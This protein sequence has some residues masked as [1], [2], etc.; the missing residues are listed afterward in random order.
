ME[1]I[2]FHWA[3][4]EFG[5]AL[6][7]YILFI[8]FLSYYA[9]LYF[10]HLCYYSVDKEL[11]IMSSPIRCPDE[12][13]FDAYLG[14]IEWL[15]T[16][17]CPEYNSSHTPIPLITPSPKNLYLHDLMLEVLRHLLY[18]AAVSP[19]VPTTSSN[20][21]SVLYLRFGSRLREHKYL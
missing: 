21:P 1:K 19:P 4:W 6:V 13:H 15:W 17:V 16:A 7:G 18:L 5:G 10:F 20:Q 11:Y 3:D 12:N 14:F 9:S 2:M 8:S